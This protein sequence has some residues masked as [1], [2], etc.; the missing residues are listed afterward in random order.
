MQDCP[1][2]TSLSLRVL[3]LVSPPHLP[4]G[5]HLRWV[6]IDIF[7]TAVLVPRDRRLVIEALLDV[8]SSQLILRGKDDQ[9]DPARPLDDKRPQTL[10]QPRAL[11][12]LGHR[13]RRG[14][15]GSGKPPPGPHRQAVPQASAETE[16]AGPSDS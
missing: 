11:S 13:I 16:T 8:Q 7:G 14:P 1:E 3:S 12:Q 5:P 4:D 6:E 2:P 15:G 9:K 10:C